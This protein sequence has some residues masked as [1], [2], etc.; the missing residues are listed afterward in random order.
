MALSAPATTEASTC[1]LGQQSAIS[2]SI[3]IATACSNGVA[4]NET[5][6]W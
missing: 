1:W 5:G 3:T 2:S 6:G 4:S